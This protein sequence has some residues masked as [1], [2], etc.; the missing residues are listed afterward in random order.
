MFEDVESNVQQ[1]ATAGYGFMRRR[2]LYLAGLYCFDFKRSL[3][4]SASQ[5]VFLDIADEDPDDTH[6]SRDIPSL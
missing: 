2:G 5:P 3:W 1:L 4:I 6:D